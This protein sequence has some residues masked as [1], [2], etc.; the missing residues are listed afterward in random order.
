M[1]VVRGL[2]QQG[3][4]VR[5]KATFLLG[6][7]LFDPDDVR[8]VRI[9]AA[10]GETILATFTGADIVH[11]ALGVF[12][13]D[14]AIP[15]DEPTNVHF[16]RWFVTASS[17]GTEDQETEHFLVLPFSTVTAHAA[18][19]TP[20]ELRLELPGDTTMSD[21]QLVTAIAL[22]QLSIE[23]VSG[24]TFLP[25]PKTVTFDGNGRGMLPLGEPIQSVSEARIIGCGGADTLLDVTQ[26]RI[27]KSK[28]ALFL[29][30]VVRRSD[31]LLGYYDGSW[32]TGR[33]G[34]ASCGVWPSGAQNIAI[35]GNWGR[36]ATVPITIRACL[37][38]LVR[39]ATFCDDP[40]GLPSN[41]FQSES[42]PG[43]RNYTLREV[44]KNVTLNNGT[45]YPDIDAILGRR[46]AAPTVG[47]A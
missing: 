21:A 9:L 17:G 6:G 32:P 15:S 4:T 38:Q 7:T 8:E 42:I 5:L 14:W 27:A 11:E 46:L 36:Y 44:W 31:R 16:D 35:S 30:N 41:A 43:D 28:T 34:S 2:A 3:Q 20:D 40:L 45:G 10:D 39:N 26:I 19:M 37:I 23:E 29:G 12:Y 25:F 47:F 13:V 18:Y 22:A 1:S 33:V 24:N